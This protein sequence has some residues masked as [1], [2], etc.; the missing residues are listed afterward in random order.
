MKEANKTNEIAWVGIRMGLSKNACFQQEKDK[1]AEMGGKNCGQAGFKRAHAS[2]TKLPTSL[3][4]PPL[5]STPLI[6]T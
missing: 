4:S 5:F 1:D 6:F 3:Y 2:P